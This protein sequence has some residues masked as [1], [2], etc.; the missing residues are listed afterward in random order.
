VAQQR[1]TA[2]EI[3]RTMALIVSQRKGEMMRRQVFITALACGLIALVAG[4]TA[5]AQLPGTAL[6]ATIP[7]D[8]NVRGKVLPAGDYEIKRITDQPGGLIISS[9]SDLHAKAIPASLKLFFIATETVTF[10][11]RSWPGAKKRDASF[12][13]H[14]RNVC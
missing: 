10:F 13:L 14:V 7:F 4:A 12:C 6:R 5:Y 1:V 11:Q 3:L 9:L 8:F 2:L